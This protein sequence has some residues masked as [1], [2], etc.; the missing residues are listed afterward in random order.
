MSCPFASFATQG[1][2]SG[3]GGSAIPS[4]CP[5]SGA[6]ATTPAASSS[7]TTSLPQD[8][9]DK[10]K[11]VPIPQPPT[12]W[13]TG[14]LSEQNPTFP[15]Q[16]IWRLAAIYGDIYQLDFV[17]E[18]SITISSNE[19]AQ[20]CLDT[21]RFDKVVAGP[22]AEI[23]DLLGDGIF[24]AHSDEKVRPALVHVKSPLPN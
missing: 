2:Q 9:I 6:S 18:K 13:F 14:N 15:A 8:E 10:T 12:R 24:T 7:A 5:F 3:S 22:L 20:E 17:T 23:R 19:L 11:L 4:A 1:D 21:N 16:S